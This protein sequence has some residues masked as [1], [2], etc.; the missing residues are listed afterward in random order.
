M[1][2]KVSQS[3]NNCNLLTVLISPLFLF[4]ALFYIH[5]SQS[6]LFQRCLN[7]LLACHFLSTVAFWWFALIGLMYVFGPVSYSCVEGSMS[8]HNSSFWKNRLWYFPTLSFFFNITCYL[9]FLEWCFCQIS[10]TAKRNQL[11]FSLDFILEIKR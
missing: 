11:T 8:F 6:Y 3:I 1:F 4:T 2:L 10:S 9:M 7:F 5:C